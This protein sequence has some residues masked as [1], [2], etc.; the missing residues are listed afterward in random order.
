MSSLILPRRDFLKGLLGLVAAPALVKAE[1]LMPILPWRPEFR[2]VHGGGMNVLSCRADD[3]IGFDL[4]SIGILSPGRDGGWVRWWGY[5]SHPLGSLP[6][7]SHIASGGGCHGL[8]TFAAARPFLDEPKPVA[9]LVASRAAEI[10][11]RS[12]MPELG[13]RQADQ[14]LPVAERNDG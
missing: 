13:V 2:F 7:R 4:A 10:A 11:P 3:L 14:F 5:S 12:A 8:A 1:T 9:S 6:C